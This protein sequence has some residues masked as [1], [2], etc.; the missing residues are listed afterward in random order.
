M[1]NDHKILVKAVVD[2]SL[3]DYIKL[4]HPANRKK[5]YLQ[6]AFVTSIAMFFDDSFTF[7][8]FMNE[9]G[10][11]MSLTDAIVYSND[12]Y[13]FSLK[14]YK[15]NVLEET[16]EYWWAKHFRNIRIPNDISINA[17]MYFIKYNKEKA[18][19]IDNK[20]Y[21]IYLDK[22][23]RMSD[24]HFIHSCLLIMLDSN[25]IVLEDE[26]IDKLSKTLY[27]FIKMNG[28]FITETTDESNKNEN[29]A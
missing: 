28:G 10:K 22:A 5:R 11:P 2:N 18:R 13:K 4:Q 6:E 17:Q 19:E 14:A 1:Q 25:K 3:T 9:Y 29:L 12:T 15:E 21:L 24:R 26:D 7:N 20:N 8:M 16:R 27:L 23:D